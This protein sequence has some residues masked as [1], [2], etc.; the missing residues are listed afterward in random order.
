M[1]QPESIGNVPKTKQL[2]TREVY[3]LT[4][5]VLQEHCQLDMST[6]TYQASDV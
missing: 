6:S 4:R 1:S 3:Q 5:Q 2:T